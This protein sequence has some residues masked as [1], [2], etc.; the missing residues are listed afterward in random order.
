VFF[1][2]FK[3]KEFPGLLV[4][5]KNRKK[6]K[7]QKAMGT[8]FDIFHDFAASREPRVGHWQLRVK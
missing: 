7:G 2:Y 3:N 8:R 1:P 5:I 6:A 4:C